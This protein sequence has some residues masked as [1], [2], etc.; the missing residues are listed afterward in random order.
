MTA[1]NRAKQ[2]WMSFCFVLL[3]VFGGAMPP[4][5]VLACDTADLSCSGT[6]IYDGDGQARKGYDNNAILGFAYDGSSVLAPSEEKTGVT[7]QR[8]PL[9]RFAESLAAEGGT[10]AFDGLMGQVR[11]AD[12]STPR[13]G[14]VFWTGYSQGNQ[15]AAMSWAEANG[16]FTIEMTPGGKWLNSLNLYGPNSTVSATEA[17]ALWNTASERFASGASG[18]I[19]AFTRGTTFNPNSA[20]YN[21]ELPILQ[22]RTIT[23]RGY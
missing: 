10:S 17:N 16:K 23:Y 9:V 1:M 5:A 11:A 14:A 21:T 19:N 20:F 15:A 22:G 3:T 13:N 6:F 18:N 2:W 8:G 12:F 4:L 7:E